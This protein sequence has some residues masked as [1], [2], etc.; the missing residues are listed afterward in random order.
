MIAVTSIGI[1]TQKIS[2]FVILYDLIPLQ[3]PDIYLK[4]NPAYTRYFT[5]AK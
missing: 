4:P 3:N 5:G 2:T 1:F